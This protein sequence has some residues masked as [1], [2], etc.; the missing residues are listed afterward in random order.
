MNK[1]IKVLPNNYNLIKKVD[2]ANDKKMFIF[3]NII[4]VLICII[5]LII[6][7]YDK[8]VSFS[9]DISTFV[10]I[11][12][13][14]RKKVLQFIANKIIVVINDTSNKDMIFYYYNLGCTLDAYSIEFHNIYLD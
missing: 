2:F 11:N 7:A 6:P 5:M 10:K 12:N 1:S 9:I 3:I 8:G 13:T 4:A 14:M